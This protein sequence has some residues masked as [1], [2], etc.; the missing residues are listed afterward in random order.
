[1]DKEKLKFA[2]KIA[3]ES[4]IWIAENSDNHGSVLGKRARATVVEVDRVVSEE[5]DSEDI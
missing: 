5:I 4:L 3:I 2:L 1:M